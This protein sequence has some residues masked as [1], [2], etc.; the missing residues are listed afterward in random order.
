MYFGLNL[1]KTLAGCQT[2]KL[3]DLCSREKKNVSVPNMAFL[4]YGDYEM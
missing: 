4:D 3:P 2:S 1:L